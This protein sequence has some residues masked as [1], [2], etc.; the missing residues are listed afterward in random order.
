MNKSSAS[1]LLFILLLLQEGILNS[2]IHDLDIDDAIISIK[3]EKNNISIPIQSFNSNQNQLTVNRIQNEIDRY[4][5]G[6]PFLVDSSPELTSTSLSN[7]FRLNHNGFSLFFNKFSNIQKQVIAERIM[8]EYGVQVSTSQIV[9]FKLDELKCTTTIYCDKNRPIEIHGKASSLSDYPIEVKFNAKKST[10]TC[11][12]HYY[13]FGNLFI[14]CNYAQ[15]LK[16]RTESQLISAYQLNR[17]GLTG[18]ILKNQDEIFMTKQ[19][20]ADIANNICLN[21]CQDHIPNQSI[22][23]VDDFIDEN[24]IELKRL[25][26]DVACNSLSK[27]FNIMKL[28][29]DEIKLM[30]ERLFIVKIYKFKKYIGLDEKMRSQINETLLFILGIEESL[31]YVREN[32]EIWSESGKSLVEQLGELNSHSRNDI[33]WKINEGRI[34]PKSLELA[35]LVKSSFRNGLRFKL[36]EKVA[37]KSIVGI[38]FEF[39]D[40]KLIYY[41]IRVYLLF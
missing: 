40:G 17:T 20:L 25:E 22:I 19:Q 5:I 23:N 9:T 3:Y 12:Q 39:T 26:F 8:S 18:L 37:G 24:N 13:L 34:I 2:P 35:M 14:R 32:K 38:S 28:N 29:V 4:V 11:L 16:K 1:T 31:N 27:Y 6:A 21:F 15:F 41:L 33:E 36:F 7:V 30:Y 10:R